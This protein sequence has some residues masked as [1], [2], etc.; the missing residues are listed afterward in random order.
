LFF[1]EIKAVSHE[2]SV[3]ENT[4]I[5]GQMTSRF[6]AKFFDWEGL[7][8]SKRLKGTP[9]KAP[10]WAS[11]KLQGLCLTFLLFLFPGFLLRLTQAGDNYIISFF[12]LVFFGSFLGKT[13]LG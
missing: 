12:L 13:P 3:N 10:G 1:V 2:K 9:D 4:M 7:S 6:D 8:S 5:V 11:K